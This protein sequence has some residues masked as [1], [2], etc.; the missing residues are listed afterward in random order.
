VVDDACPEKSGQWILNNI[1]DKR[2]S[3]IFNEE[4]QG[5]GGSTLVGFR[6]AIDRGAD[7]VVKVDGDGQMD[8]R[9]IPG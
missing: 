2:V 1:S 3:V 4:N 9:L 6:A 7:I 5:V 8:P